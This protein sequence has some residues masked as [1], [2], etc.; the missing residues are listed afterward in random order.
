MM[1]VRNKTAA[2]LPAMAVFCL[3]LTAAL[4]A[5]ADSEA[6]LSNIK[7]HQLLTTTSPEFGQITSVAP[8]RRIQLAARFEF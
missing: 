4:P 8:P 3:A 6:F 2:T 7:K 1:A 5:K